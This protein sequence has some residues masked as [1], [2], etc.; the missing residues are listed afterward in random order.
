MFARGAGDALYHKWFVS[1]RGWYAWERLGGILSSS[2]T[3]TSRG[4][5]RLDVFARGGGNGIYHKRF[6]GTAWT[7][8]ARL[9]GTATSQPTAAS[10]GSGR[11]DVVMRGTDGAM[12]LR[13][14]SSGSGWTGWTSLGGRFI[15]GPRAM[16]AGDDVRIVGRT[17]SSYVSE[18]HL[19]RRHARGGLGSGVASG[20]AGPSPSS[21]GGNRPENAGRSAAVVR[22]RSD[23]DHSPTP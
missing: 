9:G 18:R 1:G 10:P 17:S 15:S 19:I 3:A 11:L 4:T 12:W 7:S 5:R 14:Y 21:G 2:P 23:P 22:A 20:P 16:A 8:W 6:T 13:T